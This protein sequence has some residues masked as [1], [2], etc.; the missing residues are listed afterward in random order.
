[1]TT[2]LDRK[3]FV[4]LPEFAIHFGQSNYFPGTNSQKTL[5]K[6]A[7]FS[8][9]QR[10]NHFF[11]PLCVLFCYLSVSFTELLVVVSLLFGQP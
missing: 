11:F 9:D 2:T 7:N 8:M 10:M 5:E 6:V 3:L 1:M 4:Y